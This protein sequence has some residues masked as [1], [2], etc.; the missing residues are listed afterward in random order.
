MIRTSSD[1]LEFEALRQLLGR[2]VYSAL[3]RGELEKIEPSSDRAWIEAA[4]LDAQEALQYVRASQSPQTPQRGAAICPR[5]DSIPDTGPALA[6]LRIEGAAL[7]ARQI[8]EFTQLLDQAGEIRSILAAVEQFPRLAAMSA[9]IADLRPLLR[10]LRGKILPD[11][12]VSDDASVALHQVR[13]E[14]ERQQR[15]VHISLE[16]FM[17]S[18]RDDGTLQE[19]FITIRNDR[20][21]V[22]VIAGQQRKVAGVIHGTSGTGHTLFIEPMETI[23]LNN[24]LVRLRE[25]EQREV[26]RI[27]RELT[28]RLRAH[29]PEIEASVDAI[30][31]LEL[32]FAKAHF[33]SDF[34]AVIP[35]LSPV[36]ERRLA[37][38]AAR[39]PLLQDVLRKQRK[40]IVAIT[41]R[42]DEKC[43]TLLISGPNTGGKTVSMKTV[44]LLALMAH[45]GLPVPAE[46]AEFPVFDQVLA[47]IGDQQSIQESLSTFSAHIAH[48]RDMIGDV[49]RDTLVLLDEL[50][51]AT[52][53]EEGGALGVSILDQFRANG[54]FTLASTH[55][56]ALKIYGANTPGV[57]N[58]SM[59]FDEQTLEPTY[60]LRLGAPGKSAG[61]D[62]ASRLGMPLQLIDRARA[63]MSTQE[64]D[65]A[66]FLSELHDRLDRLKEQERQL[67]LQK[68]TLAGREANLAR[69]FEKREAAK[70][71]EIEQRCEAAIAVF[72][73]QARETIDKITEGAQQRKAAEQAMRRVAKTR[74]E[75]QEQVETSV[76]GKPAAATARATLEEGVSVRLRN[77]REPARVLRKLSGDRI[78]VQAGLMKMQISIDDVEEVLGT[79][80]PE[81]SRLPRNVSF[82]PAGPT[83]NVTYREINIIGKHA[84]EA[85]EEVDKFL[86]SAAMASVD[87]V[88]IV[89]GHGMGILKRAV[90]ELLSHNPRVAN[91]YQATPAEGGAGA[92]IAEL[93]Q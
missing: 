87:R 69:E 27:L 33:A 56:L 34:D 86:D 80:A 44:G 24:E 71:R 84:E 43:R 10:D 16:R 6:L 92:T 12:S 52:D 77:I 88:R 72:E 28:D 79:T 9:A 48:I 70:V 15:Q 14:I 49:T 89:H 81:T 76:L 66:L 47:D 2:Y 11:G 20:F 91:F 57:E 75:F 23:D 60:V 37:L 29:A 73:T 85:V 68:V 5:F 38:K 13:R 74:R 36:T 18:H 45:S 93:R 32:L 55:L 22:P 26:D 82:Q 53:P 67:E 65:I 3:G 90:A 51:R 30:G 61:L 35:R 17:R 40:R 19:D 39:H 63:V 46:E 50:G 4:L 54:A 31:R 25:E 42:L 83:W 64:R 58:A 1:L 62:I 41:I 21:V 78:E 8:Y 59:G 7:E